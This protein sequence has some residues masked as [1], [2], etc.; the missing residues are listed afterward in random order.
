MN[1]YI[2]INKELIPYTFNILLSNEMF[3]FRIDYNN[4]ADLFT[5]TLYKDGVA[6]CSSEPIIYGQS[7]FGD[8]INRGHFPKVKITPIDDSGEYN[9]VTFDNL[10]KTVML[11]VTDGVD[12]E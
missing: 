12:N 10:S 2:E 6:L 9:A 8:L 7:L 5:V 11:K 1:G 3:E 4:V